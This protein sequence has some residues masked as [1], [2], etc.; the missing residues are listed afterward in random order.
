[1]SSAATQVPLPS[2]SELVEGALFYPIALVVSGTVAPG[3]LMCVP[4]LIFFIALILIPIVALAIVGLLAAAVIATPFLLVRGVR[5]LGV[6]LAGS[7]RL[8]P[9]MRP[10]KI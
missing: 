5:A 8:P 9:L 4:G 3:L 10:A 7:R 1:M 6:R 2:T